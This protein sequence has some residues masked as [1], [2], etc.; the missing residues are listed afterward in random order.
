AR[1]VMEGDHRHQAVLVTAGTDPPI[2]VEGGEGPLAPLGLDT[3]PLQREAVGVEA[4]AGQHGDV[5]GIAVVLVA[6]VTA[7]LDA[8]GAGLVLPDPPVVVP[9][10]TLDLVGGRGGSP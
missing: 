8:A 6:G 3:A 7:R 9:V 10:A 2:V 5:L 1:E 4:E